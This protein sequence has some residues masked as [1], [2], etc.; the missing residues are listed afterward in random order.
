[1]GVVGSGTRSGFTTNE[2]AVPLAGALRLSARDGRIS[3]HG[4]DAAAPY[5]V[6][7]YQNNVIPKS[8]EEPRS[9]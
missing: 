2:M 5:R 7:L 3:L 8:R 6:A 9:A 1:M 4:L